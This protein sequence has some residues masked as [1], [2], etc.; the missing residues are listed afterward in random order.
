MRKQSIKWT[1]YPKNKPRNA[2]PVLVTYNWKGF[3][4]DEYD[5]FEVGIRE[6]WRNGSGFGKWDKYVI[7]FAELPEH[8]KGEK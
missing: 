1:P 7:A 4:Q 8:Y 2:S 6:Y 5:D 3:I